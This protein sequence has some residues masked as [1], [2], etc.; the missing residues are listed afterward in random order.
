MN[1]KKIRTETCAAVMNA[2]IAYEVATSLRITS[3]GGKIGSRANLISQTMNKLPTTTDAPARLK[4]RGSVQWRSWLPRLRALR[5]ETMV[6][7]RRMAPMKSMRRSF[8]GCPLGC[9]EWTDVLEGSL[10][11]M[12]TMA[13]RM[14]GPWPMNDLLLVNF[15]VAT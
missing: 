6:R 15:Y 7:A 14:S 4:I 3:A 5:N 11:D 8:D 9:E 1:G 13:M 10:R 2:D 12:R